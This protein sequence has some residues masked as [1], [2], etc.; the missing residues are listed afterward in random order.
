MAENA[1]DIALRKVL[2][3]RAPKISLYCLEFYWKCWAW[4]LLNLFSGCIFLTLDCKAQ[5]I[6]LP[7][8]FLSSCLYVQSLALDA[9]CWALWVRWELCFLTQPRLGYSFPLFNIN[10]LWRYQRL[11]WYK[12]SLSLPFSHPAKELHFFQMHLQ[13]ISFKIYLFYTQIWAS[14]EFVWGYPS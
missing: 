8:F 12:Q 11:Y 4:V 1:R 13:L 10:I 7:E 2:F 9:A 6:N 3:L 14:F 5:I